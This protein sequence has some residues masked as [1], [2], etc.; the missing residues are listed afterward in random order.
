MAHYLQ[1]WRPAGYHGRTARQG[2]FFEGWFFKLVDRSRQHIYAFIPGISLGSDPHS[3]IQILDGQT[4]QSDYIRFP[5]DQFY[6]AVNK[7]DIKIAN[8]RFTRQYCQLDISTSQRTVV[9]RVDFGPLR[10]WPVRIWSPGAM[11]WY[12]FVPFME[13]FHGVL[14]FDHHLAGSLTINNTPI[15]FD[16]GRGYIEKDW[17][18]SFPSAYIWLQSNHFDQPGISLMAS[19]ANIPWIARSFRGF[20][21]GVWFKD[22][23]YRFA[24]YTGAKLHDLKLSNSQVQFQVSDRNFTLAITAI[25]TG[26]GLLHAPYANHM[27]Q[28]VSETL[29]SSVTIE[30]HQ[31]TNHGHRLL[32]RGTG[33]PAGLDVNGNLEEIIDN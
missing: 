33:D 31:R 19:V 22:R 3:F 17:G 13:C 4:H 23:L 25:R 6:A 8:N 9:G 15:S 29:S 1:I 32:Y 30:L 10:P 24:T 12:A 27:S 7:L 2:N 16:H 28:R 14:S 26:G 5:I 21:I 20:I 18:R 11:G